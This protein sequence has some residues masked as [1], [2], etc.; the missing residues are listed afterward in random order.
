MESNLIKRDP[1]LFPQ[2][3]PILI[4]GIRVVFYSCCREITLDNKVFIQ[5]IPEHLIKVEFWLLNPHAAP[6]EG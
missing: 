6:P 3:L 1:L 4:Q 5:E 2:I